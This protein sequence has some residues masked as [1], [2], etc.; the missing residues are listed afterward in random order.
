MKNYNK[1]YKICKSILSITGIGF[2][3]WMLISCA[4]T[5]KLQVI[6]QNFGEQ[7]A[8]QQNLTFTFNQAIATPE[9]LEVW[10][11]I[12]YL[13]ITPKVKG[14][15]KWTSPT[16]L[17][18][19]PDEGFAPNTKYQVKLTQNLLAELTKKNVQIDKEKKFEFHTPY[20]DLSNSSS[21]LEYRCQRFA[22]VIIE[23]SF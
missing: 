6:D 15:F 12:E 16:M 18:F 7:I 4:S 5:E 10:Q 9:Q 2:L 13:D 23:S 14:K 3:F 11:E 1:S 22:R 21:L 19:S 17:I 20:L 8:L